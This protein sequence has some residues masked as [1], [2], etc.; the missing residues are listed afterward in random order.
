[1]NNLPHNTEAEQALIGAILINADRFDDVADIVCEEDLFSHQHRVIWNAI[2][3]MVES[4]V[5]LDVISLA[6][7]MERAGNLVD[8]GG[9]EYI[10]TI[11]A[12]T[13]SHKNAKRYAQVVSDYARE[14]RMLQA[15][16]GGLDVMDENSSTDEKL[17]HV[18]NTVQAAA[19]IKSDTGGPVRTDS[20]IRE[21]IEAL[22]ERHE[23]QGALTGLETPWEKLNEMTNGLQNGSLIIIAGRPSMGKSTVSQN[24]A[25]F[26]AVTRNVPTLFFSLE[27]PKTMVMDRAVS[28]LGHVYGSQVIT[29]NLADD[30]WPRVTNAATMLSNAPLYIDDASNLTPM[31]LRARARKINRKQKLG[32][33]VIDYLQLMHAP[34]YK[35]D[36]VHEIE[37][38]SR[39][40]KGLAKELNIP[41]I[42]LSQLNRSLESR[43]DKR[44]IMSDLRESGAIEQDADV[45]AFIYRADQYRQED[46][47]KDNIA[48]L[49][50]RKQR[51]GPTGTV[52][53]NSQLQYFKFT[54][55]DGRGAIPLGGNKEQRGKKAKGFD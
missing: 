37:E 55:H 54:E 19:E 9:L 11:T 44:P 36:K 43:A 15:L 32:L 51:N 52:H 22:E 12:N 53:L 10:G 24:I 26:A 48:E 41:V 50:I 1:M 33:I 23:K 38:I 25:E 31:Q 14:R 46:E 7:T 18:V 28:S 30:E 6:E 34:G 17:E 29:G 40:L 3:K 39:S 8:A 49:I 20:L 4:A 2:G 27:M 42:A 35:N 21:W 16:H 45:I 47:T 13:P 5:P